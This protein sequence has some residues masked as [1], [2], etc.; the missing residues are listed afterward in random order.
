MTAASPT[1]ALAPA[2]GAH[3]SGSSASA[4]PWAALTEAGQV[5]AML[6]GVSTGRPGREVRDFPELLRDAKP[7]RREE[8]ERALDELAAMMEPG[9]AALTVIN[10]CGG[11]CRP[12]AEALWA[13]FSAARAALL[14]MVTVAG[15]LGA[16]RTA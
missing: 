13:E 15:T 8:A 14:A 3:P 5:V 6:A 12:A 9:I 2:T 4:L 16:L 7:W 10:A 1:P 11:D